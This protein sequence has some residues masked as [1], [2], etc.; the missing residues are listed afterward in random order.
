VEA[1][2]LRS[3]FDIFG[4]ARLAMKANPG[5]ERFARMTT[6]MLNTRLRP[7]TAKWH[8]AL[9]A[10]IL[11]SRDGAN[12]FRGELARLRPH[13][14]AFAEELQRLAYGNVVPDEETPPAINDA[15][16]AHCLA[17]L[18]FGVTGEG[19]E[20]EAINKTEREAIA[21]RRA[22]YRC[23]AEL[24]QDAVGLSLSGGGV[25]SAVFCLGVMQVLAKRG[26]MKDFDYLSTV[27]GGG[28]VGGFISS[29]VASGADFDTIA[30]PNGPDSVGIQHIRQNA[31]YLSSASLV[32][33]WR[34]I[35]GTI[36]GLALNWVAP[37]A[38][39]SFLAL[40]AYWLEPIR[41][42]SLVYF[43]NGLLFAVLIAIGAHGVALR[44]LKTTATTGV[45]AGLAIAAIS[46]YALGLLEWGYARF[47]MPHAGL[48]FAGSALVAVA[49]PVSIRFLWPSSTNRLRAIIFQ[50]SL[51]TS[52]LLVLLLAVFILYVLRDLAHAEIEP[53]APWWNPIA[54]A[55]GDVVLF[56]IFMACF[57]YAVFGPSINLTGPHKF[58]RD[59][60]AK[61][62]IWPKDETNQTLS[63]LDPSNR[64]P[65]HLINATVNLPSS[66]SPVLRD[67]QGDFFL[68]SKGWTGS[69]AIG[70]APTIQWKTNGGPLDLATTIAISGAAA[71]P[72][73]GIGTVR[74]LSSLMTLLNIRLDYWIS[75]PRKSRKLKTPRF[76]C[77]LREMFGIGM[78]ESSS[79]LN[80][81]DGGH[82]EN[83]G[84][85]ELLRRRCKFIVCVDGE[86]DPEST[87][88]GQLTLVR[89]AQIDLGIR[90]EP[91]LDDIR[92]DP[93]SRTSRS[94]SQL[95]RIYYPP[96][97]EQ[98]E[99]I[100]LLLYL[101]LSLTGD[102]AELLKRYRLLNPDF[103]HQSTLNQFYDEE[104]FEA[105]RQ[106]GV[107]VADGVFSEALLTDNP[108]PSTVRDWFAQLAKNMLESTK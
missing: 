97:V 68:F 106:L 15:E 99:P 88:H 28:F 3:L 40:T 72:Q 22:L 85:Y 74:S 52:S 87:F 50:L 19:G 39:L 101:K 75:N 1:T 16:V 34:T 33:R 86:A 76:L 104:Q 9:E 47:H 64:G 79:W 70:Y 30:C 67:R 71:S 27:S 4:F 80:L 2:A 31:K 48:I 78:D 95:F 54:Y 24:G 29:L 51:Y 55:R 102:E 46:S 84:L 77:L 23:G 13:L 58:Y 7:I 59:Q 66:T 49:V 107:H 36:S 89:H 90:I 10:G 45:I 105:Y 63:A 73:M 61:T 108:K 98:P 14:I 11:D 94:H 38:A 6:T 26:L 65:Y 103:P 35:A 56:G 12:E 37:M 18:P 91:R 92:P 82:I 57:T 81:S 44:C 93:A 42:D 60:L 25:R 69:R 8:R 83:M 21:A 41:A 43:A 62:F 96:T 32:Q 100:G 17:P 5:C 20:S 53:T